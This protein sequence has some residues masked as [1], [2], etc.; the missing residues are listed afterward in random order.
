MCQLRINSLFLKLLK[1]KEMFTS[2]NPSKKEGGKEKES[3][4]VQ[5]LRIHATQLENSGNLLDKLL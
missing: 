3:D 1:N 2:E 5:S 4:L